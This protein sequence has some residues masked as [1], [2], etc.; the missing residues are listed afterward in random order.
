MDQKSIGMIIL[1]FGIIIGIFTLTMKIHEES[2]INSIIKEKG[3]CY[4]ADGTC[5]HEDRSV[6]PY[7]F[8][9]SISL[10][11]IVFG[12]YLAFMDKTSEKI[13]KTHEVFTK[14][15]DDS[16][17][18]SK[19]DAFL[20]GFS[21]DEKKVLSAIKEQDGIK[22]STLRFRTDLSKATLSLILKSLEERK[23]ISRNEKGKTKEIYLIKKF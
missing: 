2:Y 4:L 5:L 19:F 15:M 17:D 1:V 12:L 22:Q 23:F 21:S 9:W 7:V 16:N 8:G 10:S 3:T 14:I 20:E 13:Q 6:L 11:M 18:K